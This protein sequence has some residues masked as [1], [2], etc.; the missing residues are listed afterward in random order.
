MKS[1]K[2]STAQ[3]VAG[4]LPAMLAVSACANFAT[5][6][7]VKPPTMNAPTLTETKR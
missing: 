4:D 2:Q 6:G 3:M 5:S 1:T 7:S